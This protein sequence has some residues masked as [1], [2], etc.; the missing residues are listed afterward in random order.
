VPVDDGHPAAVR[1]IAADPAPEQILDSGVPVCAVEKAIERARMLPERKKRQE[2]VDLDA[3]TPRQRLVVLCQAARE[4]GV[5]RQTKEVRR[6]T[7]D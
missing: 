2:K 7:R 5:L 4:M 6:E 1:Q 3:M